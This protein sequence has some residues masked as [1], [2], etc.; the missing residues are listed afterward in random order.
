MESDKCV[1]APAFVN[2]F[3][4]NA[5]PAGRYY[6]LKISLKKYTGMGRLSLSC[7]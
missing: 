3:D 2:P 5:Y 1:Q 6:F 4:G 7:M